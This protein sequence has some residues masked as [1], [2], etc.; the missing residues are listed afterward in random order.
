MPFSTSEEFIAKAEDRLGVRLPDALRA[1]L[2]AEN[3]GELE[4]DDESWT[5]FPVADN[6][7]RKRVARSANHIVAEA[8]NARMWEGFPPAGVA[9]ATSGG[10]DF[11]ILL[12]DEGDPTRL[13]P[14]LYR[15][16]HETGLHHWL[17]DDLSEVPGFLGGA[18]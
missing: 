5:L 15:W 18:A 14:T 7:D 11:L 10:G 9:I 13:S 1:R 3:G 2:L 4:V 12:P 17:A 16:D 6:S 8:A